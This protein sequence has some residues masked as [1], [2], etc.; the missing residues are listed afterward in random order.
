MSVTIYVPQPYSTLR[1]LASYE[2]PGRPS[3]SV[4]GSWIDDFVALKRAIMLC[5]F[6]V[7]KF[8]PRKAHYEVWR[9]D[10][11]AVAKCDDCKQHSRQIRTF[12]HESTHY[13]VG[14]TPRTKSRRGRWAFLK[15][16]SRH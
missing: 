9:R 5:P 13:Q 7:N 2:H 15:I 10:V 12:I 6:C 16:R 11:Y 14:D 8:N 1:H 3:R 4:A